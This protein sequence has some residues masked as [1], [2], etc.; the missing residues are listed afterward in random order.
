[1]VIDFAVENDPD[2]TS[3]IAEG[4][5]SGCQIHNAEPPHA[6]PDRTIA[7]DSLVVRSTMDYGSAHLPKNPGLNPRLPELH[8]PRNPTHLLVL[9]PFRPTLACHTSSNHDF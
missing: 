3:F 9:P 5:V 7:V 8:D 2:C 6:D 4:L 1:M